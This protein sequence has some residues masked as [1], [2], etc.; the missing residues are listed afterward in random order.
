MMTKMTNIINSLL[1]DRDANQDT[2][3]KS[4]LILLL[5][6]STQIIQN[7][8]ILF[9]PLKIA[10]RKLYT[11]IA[12]WILGVELPCETQIGTNL[13]LLHGIG[14]VVNGNTIIGKNCILRHCT[15]IGNKQLGDGSYSTSPVIGNNVDIGSNVVIIGAINIG[16]NAII[17]AGSVVV[18]DVPANAIVAGNPAKIIRITNVSEE[19]HQYQELNQLSVSLFK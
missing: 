17:G 10:S 12:E 2:S 3:S 11:I 13:K 18:K 16:D 5:F 6:R 7:L 1:Q 4:R 15:T 14:L 9:F 8:P 19:C